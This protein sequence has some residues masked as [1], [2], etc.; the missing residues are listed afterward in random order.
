MIS[1][2]KAEGGEKTDEIVAKVYE[3]AVDQ[4]KIE[5]ERLKGLGVE[6]IDL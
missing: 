3:W 4:M 1:D 6:P 5:K 2:A